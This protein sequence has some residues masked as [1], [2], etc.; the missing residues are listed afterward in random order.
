MAIT[1]GSGL[2]GGLGAAAGDGLMASCGGLGTA[3]EGPGTAG[4]G[5]AVGDG[6]VGASC[7]G[8]GMTAAGELGP[9]GE[10]NGIICNRKGMQQAR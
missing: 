10:A 3:V 5:T 8:L 4:L 7:V 2:G 9:P 6:L 1:P